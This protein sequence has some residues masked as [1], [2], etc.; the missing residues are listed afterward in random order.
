MDVHPRRAKTGL[1]TTTRRFTGT[2]AALALTASFGLAGCSGDDTAMPASTASSSMAPSESSMGD[3]SMAP[4]MDASADD[5]ASDKDSMGDAAMSKGSYIGYDDYKSSMANLSGNVVLFFHASWCPDCQA[6]D[7]AIAA[8]DNLPEGL[9]IVKVDFDDNQDLR[10][11]YGITTQH[12]FV[13]VDGDGNEVK[14]WTGSKNAEDI[15]S[16]LA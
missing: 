8:D 15:A 13:Q 3:E 12:S 4:S 5:M 2:L 7:K 10:K 6:A 9:T 14:K 1:M 11:E 16:N